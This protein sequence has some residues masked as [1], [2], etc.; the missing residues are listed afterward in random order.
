MVE[1]RDSIV[2]GF[3]EGCLE[4]ILTKERIRGIRFNVIDVM[5]HRDKVHCGSDQISPMTQRAMKACQLVNGATL[6]EPL[7]KISVSTTKDKAGQIYSCLSY[8][9][10]SVTNEESDPSNPMTTIIGSLPVLESFGFDSYIKEKTSGQAFTQL[11]FEKWAQMRKD[12]VDA[13][14]KK[15]RLRKKLTEEVPALDNFLDK[16]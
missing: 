4:G 6:Q 8:K 10:G 3:L 13:N 1:I 15:A 9:K 2:A 12:I 14:I 5:A 11:T 16:L 7:F